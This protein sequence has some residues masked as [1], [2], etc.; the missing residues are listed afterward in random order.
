VKVSAVGVGMRSN[1]GI[2]AQMFEALAS[3][4]INILAITTNEIKVSV[5]IPRGIYGARRPGRSTQLRL[6]DAGK[7]GMRLQVL[8]QGGWGGHLSK[9]DSDGPHETPPP[10]SLK[11]KGA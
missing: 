4:N 2:A 11:G 1:A 6:D 9:S 7:R 10:P 5:L 8:P 3:R